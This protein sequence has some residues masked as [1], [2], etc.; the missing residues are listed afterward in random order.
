MFS[1]KKCLCHNDFSCNH[2]LLDD[3]NKL[4]GVIDFGDA[5]INDL[6][7]DFIY[8]LEDSTEEIGMS[9]GID[10][11]NLYGNID[12]KKAILYQNITEL[13]Y[14]IALIIYGLKNDN[15]EFI[16]EGRRVLIDYMKRSKFR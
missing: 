3:N 15:Q 14:P 13:Y 12:T 6:Y 10:I 4:V 8:L 5:G 16:T 9:F 7:N 11:V 2:L 1:E